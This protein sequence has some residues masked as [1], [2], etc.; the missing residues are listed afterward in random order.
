MQRL[1]ASLR[2]A[3]F[4]PGEI[5]QRGDQNSEREVRVAGLKV[6]EK[7][8]S[9]LTSSKGCINHGLEQVSDRQASER[10]PVLLLYSTLY[11]IYEVLLQDGHACNGHRRGRK[12]YL[13]LRPG[14]QASGDCPAFQFC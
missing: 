1:L 13:R 2:A 7:Y 9:F 5:R 10:W 8:A 11:D 4:K 6:E 3:K 14:Q 12:L